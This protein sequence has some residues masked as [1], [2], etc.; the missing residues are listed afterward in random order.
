MEQHRANH[1]SRPEPEAARDDL[2]HNAERH[3]HH[4]AHIHL[5]RQFCRGEGQC[6]A[7][8]LAFPDA[9]Q[10]ERERGHDHRRNQI[11]DQQAE[12]GTC[13]RQAGHRV[14]GAQ[15]YAAQPEEVEQR[16]QDKRAPP[17]AGH[18]AICNIGRVKMVHHPVFQHID[19]HGREEHPGEQKQSDDR[20]A[21]DHRGQHGQ[22]VEQQEHDHA[23]QQRAADLIPAHRLAAAERAGAGNR[24]RVDDQV[25]R[26]RAAN[27]G[28]EIVCKQPRA[29]N[30]QAVIKIHLL[31]RMQVGE[32]RHAADDRH[33]DQ[34]A[35]DKDVAAPQ[36]FRERVH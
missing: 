5:D 20:V 15:V 28:Q 14:I 33:H 24:Q 30:G 12:R 1:Q 32:Q 6:G 4:Q 27:A 2:E 25:G 13:L 31:P 7:R 8:P 16:G 23:A 9:E 36:Q 18:R 29:R 11:A 22:C 34:R 26:K 10:E 17:D 35:L 21:A 19:Q 3:A